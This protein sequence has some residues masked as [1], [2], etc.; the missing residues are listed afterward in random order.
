MDLE[1]DCGGRIGP[2]YDTIHEKN[3]RQLTQFI[4]QHQVPLTLFV[5]GQLFEEKRKELWLIQQEIQEVE[6]ALH[7]YSHPNLLTDYSQEIEKG[8][9]AYKDFMGKGP[10]GYRAPQGKIS[11]KDLACLK[12][13]QFQYDSS[14]I[15]T[16]RPGV[17]NNRKMPKGPHYLDEYNLWEI[18]CSVFP[19]TCIPMGLGYIRLMGQSV[20]KFLFSLLRHLQI[21]VFVFHLHDIIQTE[22]VDKLHGFWN[23]FYRRNVGQG[24]SLLDF[25]IKDLKKKGYSFDLMKNAQANPVQNF[26]L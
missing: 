10:L 1:N 23:F 21:I 19:S 20:T 4:N 3:I 11:S 24:F 9:T 2:V 18:P 17:F 12:K 22:H 14:I 7:S 16:I 25:V 8:V 6:F 13:H 26:Q 15:P 5:T